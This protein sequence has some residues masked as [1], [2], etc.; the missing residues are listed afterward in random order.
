MK[1]VKQEKKKLRE[2]ML[3][4]QGELSLQ[5]REESDRQI[6]RKL[7]AFPE[8]ARAKTVFCFV[9]MER[10]VNTLP[11]I[12]QALKNGKRICVPRCLALGVMEAVEIIGLADLKIGK[13]GI[14]EPKGYCKKVEKDEIDFGVI[15]CVTCDKEGNRLGYGGGFYDRYL[16]DVE[17]YKAALC[18]L[19]MICDQVPVE[20]EDVRMNQVIYDEEDQKERENR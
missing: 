9:S 8:F 4:K 10:E 2:M 14:K 12:E 18:P 15:P 13:Y 17:F 16:G 5:Y 6:Q 11:I 1:N 7:F 3:K 19:E 20:K